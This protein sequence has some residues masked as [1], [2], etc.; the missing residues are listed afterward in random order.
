MD[1]QSQKSSKQSRELELA[2]IEAALRRAGEQ[3]RRKRAATVGSVAKSNESPKNHAALSDDLAKKSVHAV[4]AAI[5][6]YNKPTFSYREESFALLMVN[7]WELLLKAKWVLDHGGDEASLYV[8]DKKNGTPKRN[9]CG[10]PLTLNVTYLSKKLNENKNSGFKQG[11][12]DNILALLEIRDTSTHF[13]HRDMHLG[14]RIL[15]IG[16]ASLHNYLQLATMWFN[17]DLSDYD[18]FLMPISFYH[19]FETVTPAFS[20]NYPEQIRKLL[21]F[22]DVLE[23][24][25]SEEDS[26]QHVALHLETKLVKGKGTSA[27]TFSWTDDPNAP[28]VTIREEDVLKNYPMVYRDLT[29]AMRKRYVDFVENPDFHTIKE[30]L[31]KE[32]KYCITR[33]L[34]PNNTKSLGQ[35]FYNPNILQEFDKHYKRKKSS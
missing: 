3:A 6:I 15:E 27:V 17:L 7:A 26:G 35:R 4:L 22:L 33:R 2:D 5:E 29:V 9:R 12:H 30:D 34:N 1:T 21:E 32:K 31:W 16:T 24:S 19:G 8:L 11:C 13:L 18:F 23:R 14:R 28:R 10:N 20:V 25:N